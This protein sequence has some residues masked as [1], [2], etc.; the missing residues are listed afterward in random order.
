MA[1]PLC[2]GPHELSQC[3]R[4][5]VPPMKAAIAIAGV[6]ALLVLC[7][8]PLIR[9]DAIHPS[10]GKALLGYTLA[11]VGVILIFVGAARAAA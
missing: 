8:W 2:Q 7:G 4:W 10:N 5:K 6:G 9:A 11:Y 3:P 1:C